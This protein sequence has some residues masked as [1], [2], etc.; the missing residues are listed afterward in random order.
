MQNHIVNTLQF[1]IRS[2]QKMRPP[3]VGEQCRFVPSCSCYASEAL[4]KHGLRALPKI[5]GRICRCHPLGSRGIEYDP[6]TKE[7]LSETKL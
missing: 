3:V 6:V 5:M 4:D 1:L 7:S 2:Y